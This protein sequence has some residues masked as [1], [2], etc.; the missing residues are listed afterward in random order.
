MRDLEKELAEFRAD[1]DALRELLDGRAW[2]LVLELG[3][4]Q[5]EMRYKTT[6][7]PALSIEDILQQN[8]YK[9]EAAGIKI[10]LGSVSAL[11]ESRE[12]GYRELLAEMREE[13]ADG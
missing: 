6:A 10:I 2:R 11:L 13:R 12:A 3:E 7:Q 4:A 8:V 9:A 1:I 5:A